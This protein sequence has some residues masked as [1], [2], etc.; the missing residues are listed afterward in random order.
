MCVSFFSRGGGVDLPTMH[1]RSHDH[2]PGG[3]PTGKRVCFH[4]ATS[5]GSASRGVCLQEGG[6]PKGGSASK[7]GWADPPP[8][9]RK[10]SSTHPTGMLSC[11]ANN[12]QS[13]TIRLS[14]NSEFKF[15]LL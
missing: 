2:H 6:L 7:S 11:L 14:E 12:N 5:G 1:H 8:Q 9:I 3:L 4:E 10:A 13:V 15:S